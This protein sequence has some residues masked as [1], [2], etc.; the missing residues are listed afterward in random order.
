MGFKKKLVI[1]CRKPRGIFGKWVAKGMNKGHSELAS[2]GVNYISINPEDIILDIGC[3][4]GMNIYNFAHKISSGKVFG[5]DYSD[6]SVQMSKKLNKNFI[7][8][9][10]VEIQKA[11]VSSLP[12]SENSFDLVTGFETYYFW[13]DLIN[14]LKGILKV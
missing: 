8:S 13:P 14:D 11:S 6:V 1:Q 2:W 12:F 4:G 9:G 5:I 7:E 3:G 10:I